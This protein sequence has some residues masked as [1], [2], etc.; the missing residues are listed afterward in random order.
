MFKKYLKVDIDKPEV[1]MLSS[2]FKSNYRRTELKKL[3]FAAVMKQKWPRTYD[4]R[5]A[6]ATSE[7]LKSKLDGQDLQEWLKKYQD[8]KK[9][10]VVNIA[11]LKQ[12]LHESGFLEPEQVDNFVAFMEKAEDGTV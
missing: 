9:P 12:A 4:E 7:I 10:G 1:E 6:R 3:E 5:A 8:K 11:K 2:Y